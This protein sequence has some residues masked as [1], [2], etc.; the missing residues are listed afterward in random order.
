MRRW[1][2]SLT[3]KARSF[4]CTRSLARPPRPSQPF[5]QKRILH[6]AYTRA[7]TRAGQKMGRSR[8]FRSLRPRSRGMWATGYTYVCARFRHLFSVARRWCKKLPANDFMNY[9]GEGEG[10]WRRTWDW[11]R[12]ST[13]HAEMRDGLRCR[14]EGYSFL[15]FFRFLRLCCEF[16]PDG[17]RELFFLVSPRVTW[18]FLW[19]SKW[20]FTHSLGSF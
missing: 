7:H 8:W 18:S 14:L 19:S 3:Q 12:V 9:G 13:N 5:R 17:K 11:T 20:N 10:G 4:R 1:K 16:R 15:R 6:H 2:N